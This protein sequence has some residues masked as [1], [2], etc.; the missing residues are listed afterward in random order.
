[1]GARSNPCTPSLPERLASLHASLGA[2]SGL[3]AVP[4]PK[5]RKPQPVLKAIVEILESVDGPMHARDIHA[6]AEELLGAAVSWSSLKDC[7]STHAQGERPRFRRLRRGWYRLA[8]S[9]RGR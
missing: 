8:P 2:G 7:L 5:R 3:A 4:R 6:A 1:M 9:P